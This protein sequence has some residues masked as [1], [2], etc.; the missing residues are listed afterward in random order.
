MKIIV[1]NLEVIIFFSVTLSN[2][3]TITG[4]GVLVGIMLIVVIVSIVGNIL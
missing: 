1:D 4:L 2:S 3:S